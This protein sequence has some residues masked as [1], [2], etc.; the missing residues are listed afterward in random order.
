MV[1]ALT[2]AVVFMVFLDATI[3]NGAVRPPA[4]FVVGVAFPVDRGY[5]AR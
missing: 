2:S 4:G 1:L 3:V 5:V